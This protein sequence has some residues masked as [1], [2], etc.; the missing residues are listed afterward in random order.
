M[1]TGALFLRLFT[2]SKSPQCLFLFR[3]ASFDLFVLKYAFNVICH[4]ISFLMFLLTT[5]SGKFECRTPKA[6]LLRRGEG[7][8]SYQIIVDISNQCKEEN[9]I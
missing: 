8:G 4:I 3:E 6:G 1:K 9:E 2:L 5:V 7:E